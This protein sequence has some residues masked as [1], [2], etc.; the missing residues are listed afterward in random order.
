MISAM[1]I[2][3]DRQH[4]VVVEALVGREQRR[5]DA[6]AADD[7]DHGGVPQV[8]VEL[9]DREADEA[10]HHLRRDTPMISTFMNDAPVARTAST[11]F[12]FISSTIS[13][14]SFETKP[15]VDD[16]QRQHAGQRA[17]ADGLHEQDR[18]DDAGGTS[19]AR[20]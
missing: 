4:E 18:D 1:M 3:Q 19:A 20:R 8:G 14:K 16:D 7:A 17:K 13:A 11:C 12:R 10:G 2:E 9:V 15:T 6:A 5:A